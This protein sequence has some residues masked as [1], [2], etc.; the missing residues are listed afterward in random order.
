MIKERPDHHDADLVIKLYDLRR[1]T[2]MRASRDAIASKF[3]PKR[4]ED[5]SAVVNNYEHELNAPWRQ[6]STYWEM[7]YGFAKHGIINPDFLA[8]N[9][10]EGFFLFA[11]V[12]PHL[13]R[14][15]K[16]ISPLALQNTEWMILNSETA[17][18]RFEMIRE[19]V[20]KM[21]ES[22]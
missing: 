10:G 11:K 8:E 15:R 20:K 13:E 14:F 19:R 3:W 1:E 21:A 9:A 5:I 4:Y 18:K 16:E 12:A 6:V 22:K 17:K 2:V 7:V